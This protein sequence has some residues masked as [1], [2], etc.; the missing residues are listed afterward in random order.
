MSNHEN[1]YLSGRREWNERYGSYIARAANWQ[2]VAMA[3][4]TIAALAVVGLGISASQSKFVP[5]VVEVDS[6][7]RMAAVSPAS[8]A[9]RSDSRIIRAQLADFIANAKTVTA[10]AQVQR[11]LVNKVYAHLPQSGSATQYLNDFFQNTS[12][13]ER[14]K[15]ELVT[16]T[17][18]SVLPLSDDSWQVEW[19]E[20]KRGMNGELANRENWKATITITVAPPST[21]AE[22]FANPAGVYVKALSWQKML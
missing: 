12:P 22:I 3:T 14:A 20:E 11:G 2:K 19:S 6:L 7:G 15:T 16:V 4:S 17:P 1:P 5:Y 13:F 18:K 10:D 21:E 8:T 9:T